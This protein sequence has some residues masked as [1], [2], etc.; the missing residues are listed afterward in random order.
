MGELAELA[1]HVALTDTCICDHAPV[2]RIF[3]QEF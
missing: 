2:D 1:N 3:L